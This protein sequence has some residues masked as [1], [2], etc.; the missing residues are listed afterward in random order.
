MY[1]LAYG[2]KG[3]GYFMK[4]GLKEVVFIID[5]SMAMCCLRVLGRAKAGGKGF[6]P[7]C[8]MKEY[9]IIRIWLAGRYGTW[10]L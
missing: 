10:E 6:T 7:D 8:R 3:K 9:R 5:R 1:R 4:K 2:R